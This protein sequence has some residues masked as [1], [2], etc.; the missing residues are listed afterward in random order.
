MGSGQPPKYFGLEPPL[1]TG[2]YQVGIGVNAA[3]VAGVAT[4]LDL[5]GS[6]CV[7]DP[8]IF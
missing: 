2:I 6:S 7:D 1:R 4:P 8:L 3:G 5:H